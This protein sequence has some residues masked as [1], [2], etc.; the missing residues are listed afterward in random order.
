MSC[1]PDARLYTCEYCN[2]SAV[3]GAAELLLH[4]T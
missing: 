2:A 4:T 1:E 3:F